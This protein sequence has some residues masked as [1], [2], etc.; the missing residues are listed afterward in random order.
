[1]PKSIHGNTPIHIT[2][3]EIIYKKKS[4]SKTLKDLCKA[5]LTSLMREIKEDTE[6]GEAH[7]TQSSI[8]LIL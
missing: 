5:I 2:I 7:H 1:M 4:L 3:N 6:D 8:E